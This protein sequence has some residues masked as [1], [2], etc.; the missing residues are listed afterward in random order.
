[1]QPDYVREHLENL[2]AFLDTGIR[3]SVE[4]DNL[5]GDT[6]VRL[7]GTDG[8]SLYYPSVH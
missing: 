8:V 7:E 4:R 5:S 3:V 1:M 6:V 2:K